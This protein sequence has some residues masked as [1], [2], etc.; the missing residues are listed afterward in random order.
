MLIFY[1]FINVTPF[2]GISNMQKLRCYFASIFSRIICT[3]MFFFFGKFQT[4]ILN[5]ICNNNA[6]LIKILQIYLSN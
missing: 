1:S 6:R 2:G 5:V 4:C 3:K